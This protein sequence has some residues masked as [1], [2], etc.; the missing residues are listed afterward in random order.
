MHKVLGDSQLMAAN[1]FLYFL[2]L[3]LIVAAIIL[4]QPH[5]VHSLSFHLI[6][7]YFSVHSAHNKI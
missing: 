1:K 2:F 7:F 3:F 4:A 6:F 5:F